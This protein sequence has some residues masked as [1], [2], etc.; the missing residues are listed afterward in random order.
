M[1]A[2]PVQKVSNGMKL[3]FKGDVW[4]IVDFA[5]VK[6]GK[7]GAFVRVKIKSLTTGRVLEETFS[8][9]E[10]VE[11]VDVAFRKMVYLYND[12]NGYHFMD[13]NTYEQVQISEQLIDDK[14][15]FLTENLEVTALDWQDRIIGVEMPTKVDLKV[16]ETFDV[17]GGN[18]ATGATKE[19][20]VQTG[21]KL[22]VPLFVKRGDMIRVD[23]RDGKYETRV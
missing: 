21:F 12:D 2:I 8:A 1:T 18:T 22:Q 11:Q 20:T 17:D 6:P 7:G 5:H 15:N 9:S 4:T 16:T 14:V 13:N 23:T 10:K 19:A 3:E